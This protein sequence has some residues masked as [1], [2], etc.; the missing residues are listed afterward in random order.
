MRQLR[1]FMGIGALSP[2]SGPDTRDRLAEVT[3]LG[4]EILARLRWTDVDAPGDR[5]LSVSGIALRLQDLDMD[6]LRH[7]P[8]CVDE[9]RP[10]P[11]VNSIRL[12]AACPRHRL[13]L[14]AACGTCGRPTRLDDLGGPWSCAGCGTPLALG[15]RQRADADELG[16]V[17]LIRG[18]MSSAADVI[19][20]DSRRVLPT[21][22]RDLSPGLTV[23][24]VER[25]A[26]VGAAIAGRETVGPQRIEE[27]RE[28]ARFARRLLRSW[29]AMLRGAAPKLM[30]PWRAGDGG[31]L[32][33]RLDT[34]GGRLALAP[35]IDENGVPITI[36]ADEVARAVEAGGSSFRRRAPGSSP[37][38][39]AAGTATGR[40][41]SHAAAME[42]LEGRSDD[43]LARSW[44][45]AGILREHQAGDG[46]ATL[47]EADVVRAERLLFAGVTPDHFAI[48]R[49][50]RWVD[51]RVTKG[52]AYDKSR[53]LRDLVAGRIACRIVGDEPG[54]A[55][56]VFDGAGI[57]RFRALATI[58][59]WRRRDHHAQLSAYN[60]VARAAW[61]EAGVLAMDDCDALAA[62]GR[63]TP[64]RYD[65]PT[66]GARPQKRWRVADL[67]ALSILRAGGVGGLLARP[68]IVPSR[69]EGEVNES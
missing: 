48:E 6:A 50:L 7:C 34:P 46:T 17:R 5:W 29:P 15:L 24:I 39:R 32:A 57:E 44:I 26:D 2:R 27:D 28:R 51:D 67:A 35:I 45:R 30:R 23:A 20:R 43:R 22:L 68:R 54:L 49:D 36:V 4:N 69:G 62:A 8:A 18:A 56:M 58:D 33:A 47:R 12:H 53:F 21:L 16:I 64:R 14:A 19:E 1:S 37:V 55:G 10:L 25:L 59:A 42:R 11:A 52:R 41:I 3:G 66:D 63:T 40:P 13:R 60:A 65:P 61:G 9:G 31:G 38:L